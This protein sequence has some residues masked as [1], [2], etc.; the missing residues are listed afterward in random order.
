MA[1]PDNNTHG[2]LKVSNSNGAHIDDPELLMEVARKLIKLESQSLNELA[3]RLDGTFLEALDLL[4]FCKGKIV[5]TGLGKSGIAAKKISATLASTGAP[6]LFLHAAEAIHGDMGVVSAG[7]IILAISYSGETRELTDLIPRLKLL[8]VTVIALTGT[9]TSALATLA[10]LHLD[11]SVPKHEWPFGLLPTSSNATTVALGDA[12]AVALLVRRGIKEEDF[13][14]LHPGGLLGGKMLVKVK[15]LMHGGINIP[16]VSPDASM[17]Q[18]IMEMTTKRLGTVCV[19]DTNGELLGIF[20]DGDLRRL[21][22][23]TSNPFD[24]TA[25]E[26]MTRNPKALS[27]DSLSA[28]ALRIME[29]HSITTLPVIND[30]R[31]L[32][33]I[34]HMHDIVKLETIR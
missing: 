19:V 8:G 29:Q 25:A 13:A 15:D 2:K 10:D 16:M 33:G 3:Q 21:L 28:R 17:K 4:H 22:E 31:K 20:T 26:A 6:S 14:M 11:V 27:P 9:P 23:K 7:D 24:L 32:V 5:V 18:A 12:L 34:I 1:V 30:G